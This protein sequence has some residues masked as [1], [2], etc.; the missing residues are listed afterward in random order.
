M[1]NQLAYSI[2]C[3]YLP[4][5]GISDP[6]L[7]LHIFVSLSGL[8]CLDVN[9]VSPKLT[10]DGSWLGLFPSLFLRAWAIIKATF[11]VSLSLS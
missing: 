6:E 1:N 11:S 9:S 2:L 5:V 3:L 8:S 10:A 4:L 7:G